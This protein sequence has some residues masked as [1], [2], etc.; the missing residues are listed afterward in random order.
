MANGVPRISI[1][2][3]TRDCQQTLPYPYGVD[4]V[5][6]QEAEGPPGAIRNIGARRA[7]G[8]ILVF[9]DDDIIL[10]GNLNWLRWRP[11]AEVWWPVAD[12]VDETGDAFSATMA[13]WLNFWIHMKVAPGLG[14]VVA[15]RR[16]AWQAV[17]GYSEEDVHEDTS[18]VRKLYEA[19]GS[20]ANPMPVHAGV[21]RPFSPWERIAARRGE[22]R[23]KPVPKDGPFRRFLPAADGA[24]A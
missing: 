7:S 8:E 4:E 1:V 12:Y 16:V 9:C 17:G 14:P 6:L 22:W 11:A 2:V 24:R 18:F 19:F 13:G 23:G 20:F 10:A 15:V 5:V 21:H 3:P